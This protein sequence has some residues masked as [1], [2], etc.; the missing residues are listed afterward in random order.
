MSIWSV[1]VSAVALL[2]GLF[3]YLQ[4][5][6]PQSPTPQ[7]WSV[8]SA[9][10]KAGQAQGDTVRV[11]VLGDLH[12][13]PSEMDLFHECQGHLKRHLDQ[14]ASSRVVSL[15]DLAGYK[16]DPGSQKCFDRAEGFLSG[17]GRP[18]NIVTG[19]HDLESVDFLTD[20]QNLAAW[21]KTFD[22]EPYW[23]TEVSANTVFVGLSTVRFRDSPGSCHEV[24]VDDAQFEWFERTV[25]Q[26][27]DWNVFVFS[28]A[29]IL[30]CNLKALQKVHIKNM[31]AWMNHSDRPERFLAVVRSSPQIKAWFSGH[32]HLS[33]DYIDSI[34]T[35]GQC[36]FVQVGVMGES[37]Q[38]DKRRQTRLLDISSDGYRV[39]TVNHHIGGSLRL[40]L[41]K[42]YADSAPPTPIA[43]AEAIADEKGFVA[44]G[45]TGMFVSRDPPE[46]DGCVIDPDGK[47]E[48]WYHMPN[49]A[50]LQM[51]DNQ[52]LE[53]EPTTRAPLGLVCL[54]VAGR[55]IHVQEDGSI[56][57][58]H[59]TAEEFITERIAPNADGSYRRIFQFNKW[60]TRGLQ[61]E[62]IRRAALRAT[63]SNGDL[64]ATQCALPVPY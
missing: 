25:E 59:S 19:N 38:R 62:A 64:E 12:L 61:E 60:K 63:D 8:C 57:L 40:D 52:L 3:G 14:S 37:S 22:T 10:G 20:E 29:P 47:V 33:H 13:D 42:G 16:S 28:H 2:G 11:A 18:Y 36:A 35:V 34:S 51:V 7:D 6:K 30:G 41:A 27:K 58:V 55:E 15:G 1:A 46:E 54:N 32:F 17:F 39:Y 9:S 50:L 45:D 44:S 53:Y 5:R 56:L 4:R 43:I 24:W 48:C 26:Y 21:K 31:C 23:C 49:G